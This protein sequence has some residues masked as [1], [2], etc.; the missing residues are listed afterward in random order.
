[1]HEHLGRA[2]PRLHG[3]VPLDQKFGRNGHEVGRLAT[4][5][6]L[7]GIRAAAMKWMVDVDPDVGRLKK[8]RIIQKTNVWLGAVV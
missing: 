3:L 4:A 7:L 6:A 5:A 8:E 2:S 1:M